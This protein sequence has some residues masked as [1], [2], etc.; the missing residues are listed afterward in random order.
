ME[1]GTD[2]RTDEDDVMCDLSA[3]IDLICATILEGDG[4]ERCGRRGGGWSARK[5]RF[6]L[7]FATRAIWNTGWAWRGHHCRIF[8]SASLPEL[9]GMTP[10]RGPPPHH[11]V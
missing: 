7:P 3:R 10:P 8:L 2:G 1:G 6:P 5:G 4:D 9:R 11:V